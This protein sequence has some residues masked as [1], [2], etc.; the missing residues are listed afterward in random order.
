MALAL[1]LGAGDS[2]AAGP[3]PS[4][5]VLSQGSTLVSARLAGVAV[6]ANLITHEVSIGKPSDP[7]PERPLLNC[8]YS[9]VPCSLLDYLELRVGDRRVD[10][11][12]SAFGELSDIW[13]ARLQTA[14]RGRYLLILTGGD[15]AAAYSVKL[16]F[17]RSRVIE[18]TVIDSEAGRASERTTYF[19][20]SNAF[21]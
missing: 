3:A 7:M 16:L 15:A 4:S 19:D 21:H 5:R 18:R 2:A 14:G 11:P 1:A 9:H 17:N 13:E 20:L 10:V 8:T 6:S 12:R